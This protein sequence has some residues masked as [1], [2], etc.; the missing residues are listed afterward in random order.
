[1]REVFAKYISERRLVFEI[2]KE[3]KQPKSKK[4]IQLKWAKY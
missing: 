1:M 4:A 2:Y 3:H